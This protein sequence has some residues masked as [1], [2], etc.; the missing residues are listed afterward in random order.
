MWRYFKELYCTLSR[1]GCGGG[2]IFGPKKDEVTGDRA[3][4]LTSTS[5]RYYQ[6]DKTR[7]LRRK[8]HVGV[9]KDSH[10]LVGNSVEKKASWLT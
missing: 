9:T 1:A 5:T 10:I 4:R 6:G 3:N 2:G 7:R 8:L